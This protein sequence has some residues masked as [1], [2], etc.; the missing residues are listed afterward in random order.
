MSGAISYDQSGDV[1]GDFPN[2][3]TG[4]GR[5]IGVLEF[6]PL[7]TPLSDGRLANSQVA[8]VAGGITAFCGELKDCSP[9]S[10]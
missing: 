4:P 8:Y 7:V 10:S 2:A 6:V 3:D 1:N 5:A 9:S